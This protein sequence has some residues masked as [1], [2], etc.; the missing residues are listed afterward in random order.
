MN[1]FLNMYTIPTFNDY[2]SEG[3]LT[4]YRTEREGMKLTFNQLSGTFDE[5]IYKLIEEKIPFYFDCKYKEFTRIGYLMNET[6]NN[7]HFNGYILDSSKSTDQ[8]KHE[9]EKI[10]N[11]VIIEKPGK[12]NIGRSNFADLSN[13]TDID[14]I[15]VVIKAIKEYKKNKGLHREVTGNKFEVKIN[16]DLLTEKTRINDMI[17]FIF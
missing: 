2:I 15:L 10:L 8:L 1:V 11:D 7:V 14:T 16:I 17:D 12:L 13:S 4:N 6:I 5:F 9:F 3:Y